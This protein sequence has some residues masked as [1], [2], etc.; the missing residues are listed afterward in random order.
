MIESRGRPQ[1]EDLSVSSGQEGSRRFRLPGRYRY[2]VAG[3]DGVVNVVGLAA[4]SPRPRGGGCDR[5][6]IRRYDVGIS[7]SKSVVE[8]WL[9][10]FRKRGSFSISYRYRARFRNVLLAVE[11]SCGRGTRLELPVG[12]RRPHP[13]SASLTTYAWSDTV[14]D[15]DDARPPACSFSVARGDLGAEIHRTDGFIAPRSRGASFFFTAG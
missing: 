13:G 4:R 3:R 7:A 15:L 12:S 9:P 14:Q 6:D 8:Q 1:F 5:L 10:E 11:R 2:E